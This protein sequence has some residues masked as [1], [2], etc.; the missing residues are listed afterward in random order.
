MDEFNILANRSAA[1]RSASESGD[2]EVYMES[3]MNKKLDKLMDKLV[4]NF[5]DAMVGKLTNALQEMVQPLR[6]Q[7]KELQKEVTELKASNG[8][9]S[10][11]GKPPAYIMDSLE[12]KE[13]LRSIVVSG[14]AET[15]GKPSER[16][17]NDCSSIEKLIDELNVDASA[18]QIFR[19]GQTM[20]TQNGTNS[21]PGINSKPRLLKVV[22]QNSHQQKEMVKAA[23]GLKNS[24]VFKGVYIR[25]SLTIAQRV[26][27]NN[28]QIELKARRQKNERVVMRGWPGTDSRKIVSLPE[29]Q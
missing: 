12:E 2:M 25:P 13:R 18:V 29:N 17:S 15:T 27:E 21:K 1:K 7:I 3:L 10:S 6:D 16:H 14:V 5:M 20:N 23:R 4:K 9:G 8:N 19:M 28:F 22:L 24:I 11:Y 26:Q